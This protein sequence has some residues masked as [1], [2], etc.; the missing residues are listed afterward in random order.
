M[1]TDTDQSEPDNG[2]GKLQKS[3]K[4]G[5]SKF[6][7]Q[8]ATVIG[9][10]ALVAILG[11]ITFQLIS[12]LLVLFLGILFAILLRGMSSYLSKYTKLTKKWALLVVAAVLLLVIG[13]AGWLMAPAVGEQAGRVGEV[14]PEAITGFQRWL[15][16]TTVGQFLLNEATEVAPR[17]FSASI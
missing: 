11:F 7:R 14:I 17:S 10:V 16:S 4:W 2:S 13:A 3:D 9:M 8:A 6:T 5:F 12:L 15:E 1:A